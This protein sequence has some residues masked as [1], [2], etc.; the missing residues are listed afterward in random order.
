MLRLA[1]D[2]DFNNRILRG[3]LRRN[4][5]LDIVRVQDAGL[6]GKGDCEILEWVA[7]EGRVLLTH[8]VTTME[9]HAY[10][11]IA[12]GL[13]MPGVFELSQQ[14]AISQAIDEILFVAKYSLKNEWEG[15]V[16]F[17]PLR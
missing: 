8:D 10:D 13:P 15:K 9:R 4:P 3:L 1:T 7:L 16:I 5:S 14:F 11:R 17:L 2:E 12:T 6:M